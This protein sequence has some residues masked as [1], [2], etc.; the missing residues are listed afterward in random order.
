MK[1]FVTGA[2]GFI[3]SAVVQE[4]ITHGHTVT[5]LARSEE[6][7]NRLK[8][9]NVNVL[10]GDLTNLESLK[11]GAADADG[12]IHTGFI[13]DF[14][15]F[16]ENC[17][18]DRKAIEVFG[19][20]FA[21]TN[22][23]LIVTSGLADL[24]TRGKIATEKMEIISHPIMT[25][26]ESEQT[27]LHL[28]KTKNIN[29]SVVRLAPAVHGVSEHDGF[30]AG[31]ASV[32]IGIARRSGVSAYVGDGLNLWPGVH[33]LDAAVLFRL[34]LEKGAAGEKYHGVENVGTS[35]KDL[36][37]SIGKKLN[38]PVKS[39]SEEETAKHF[40]W[41]SGFTRANLSASHEMT[42]EKLGW[43]PTHLRLIEDLE[44]AVLP[45]EDKY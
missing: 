45:A 34:A 19:E 17:E 9:L 41:F 15:K 43:K 12:I 30:M 42:S 1:V 35:F 16:K 6:S 25:P 10:R 11:K 8:A 32:L 21:G 4:L 28:V 14:T 27:A 37:M 7:A 29:A 36:A 31:F 18:I 5:G 26:R 40:S 39:L 38:V 3:G 20:V 23:P 44:K 22:R 13:H 33:R 24:D 2:T